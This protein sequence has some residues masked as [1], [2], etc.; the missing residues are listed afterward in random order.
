ML[1]LKIV[2]NKKPHV[3]KARAVFLIHVVG[4]KRV[5]L[6][7]IKRKGADNMDKRAQEFLDNFLE[8][9]LEENSGTI[10]PSTLKEINHLRKEMKKSCL[11]QVMR[12]D[13]GAVAEG[14][15]E[16]GMDVNLSEAEIKAIMNGMMR[17]D[18]S[19]YNEFIHELILH[20]VSSIKS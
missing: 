5:H 10:L 7:K 6:H 8:R 19:E 4:I 20:T 9:W 3:L 15:K 14:M 18:H 13:I 11:E 12:E 17:Y 1:C 16:D 2:L